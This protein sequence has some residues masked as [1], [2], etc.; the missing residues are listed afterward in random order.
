M[1]SKRNRPR[2]PVTLIGMLFLIAGP[3]QVLAQDESFDPAAFDVGLETV[4][5]GFDRPLFVTHAGDDRLFVVEKGG[6]IRVVV[7][8]VTGDQPFLDITDRVGSSSSEQGLLGLAFAPNYADSGLFYVYYTDLNGNTV[9]SRFSTPDDAGIAEPASEEIILAQDQPAPNHNGGMLAFGPDNYL[10][11]GLGDGGNQ[12]DPNGNGQRLDTWLGKIL[13]LEVDPEYT[14]GEPYGIP[15]DNPF[16]GDSDALPEI[17]AYGLRNPWRFSFDRETGDLWV[18]DVGQNEYE[19]VSV[20]AV[21]EGG[22][23]LGWNI[24][25][26][27][28]CYAEPDCDVSEFHQPVFS[29]NR[30]GGCSVIGGYV[31]RG[32]QF[33]DIFG[34][35][36]LADYCSGLIWGG[37]LD[38]ASELVFSEPLET[39]LNISSFGEGEDGE[40]YLTDLSGGGVYMLAPPL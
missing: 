1:P 26:G 31:Y 28:D 8:G 18:G 40:V 5:S 15:E 13:R 30:S 35:Y 14:G 39:G 23:N 9:V 16:V 2:F 34:V 29:Y 12:G 24:V 32:E 19:E 3:A 10:Y 27:P 38:A 37:G 22:A 17:W 33:A 4:A 6:T 7:D 25:E 36:V 21:D 11:I 20:L